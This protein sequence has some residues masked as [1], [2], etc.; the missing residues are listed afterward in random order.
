M[1]SARVS[2]GDNGVAEMEMVAM[3]IGRANHNGTGFLPWTRIFAKPGELLEQCQSLEL[4]RI[5]TKWVSLYRHRA[6]VRQIYTAKQ[7]RLSGSQ[8]SSPIT[9]LDWAPPVLGYRRSYCPN[10]GF[11]QAGDDRTQGAQAGSDKPRR[12]ATSQVRQRI[13]CLTPA[14]ATR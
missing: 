11:R 9:G 7:R 5:E 4:Q 6:L 3:R 1:K 10:R 2:C 12:H 8:S 14:L 13:S